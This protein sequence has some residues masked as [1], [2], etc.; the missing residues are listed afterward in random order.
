MPLTAIILAQKWGVRSVLVE[1]DEEAVELSR[2]LIE[3][4]G[5]QEKIA[6]VASDFLDYR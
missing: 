5:L 2:G 1:K 6:V 4:L 3:A